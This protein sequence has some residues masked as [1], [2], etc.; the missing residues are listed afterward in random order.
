MASESCLHH[1]QWQRAEPAERRGRE[2]DGEQ[3][4]GG[5]RQVSESSG[6]T[7]PDKA[8]HPPLQGKHAFK[9]PPPNS[10]L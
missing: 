7:S 1:N 8:Q 6:H 3:R 5:V 4:A 9:Q 10:P 2:L